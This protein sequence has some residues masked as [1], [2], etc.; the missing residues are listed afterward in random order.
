MA[1]LLASSPE[2]DLPRAKEIINAHGGSC[3]AFAKDDPM[4]PKKMRWWHL[5]VRMMLMGFTGL[6]HVMDDMVASWTMKQRWKLVWQGRVAASLEIL[7]RMRP[8]EVINVIAIKGGLHCDWEVEQLSDGG[9]LKK[10]FPD[11][12]L[13]M[14]D[15]VYDLEQALSSGG[16]E[17][18]R[19]T[20]I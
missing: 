15:D 16:L 12:K 7:Q 19:Q 18:F 20:T 13:I 17:A 1:T 9:E 8:E 11:V 10:L 14:F 2:K 6:K 4:S 3:A 5:I